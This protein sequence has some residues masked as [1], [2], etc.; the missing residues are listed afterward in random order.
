MSRRSGRRRV[1]IPPGHPWLPYSSSCRSA[2]HSSGYTASTAAALGVITAPAVVSTTDSW[3]LIL[4]PVLGKEEMT[5]Q[6]RHSCYSSDS[7]DRL[8]FRVQFSR[9]EERSEEERATG[10]QT[11]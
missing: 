10:L 9:S 11:G 8:S 2:L 7:Q 1:P 5:S 6:L 3:A 4:R